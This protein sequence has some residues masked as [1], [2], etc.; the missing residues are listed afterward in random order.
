M[1]PEMFNGDVHR[2][3]DQY[4]LGVVVYE[5]LS[6]ARPFP[7]PGYLQ[8]GHQHVN[9]PPPPLRAKV[10]DLPP[11]VEQV[12]LRALAKDPKQRYPSVRAFAEALVQA[13]REPPLGT[14]VHTLEGHAG[15]VLS[16]AW[17][18]DGTRLASAG[19]DKTVRVWEEASGQALRILR[20]L[21]GSV[22]SVAWSPDGTR[23]AS[24]SDNGEVVLWDAANGKK[25]RTLMEILA[26]LEQEWEFCCWA[27]GVKYPTSETEGFDQFCSSC[28]ADMFSEG[29]LPN[30]SVKAVAWSSNRRYLASAGGLGKIYL[31][32]SAS[33]QSILTCKG[34]TRCVNSV[35][36]SPD[37]R[38]L[39][40]A[41]G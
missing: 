34:H 16:V 40:S 21:G 27:C 9:N 26:F 38:R 41:S 32:D 6:G 19:D 30:Y 20:G 5:W 24:A 25:L 39:A 15:S 28:G 31:W 11:A 22:H 7:G 36:W 37:A 8:Y 14:L 29:K 1:A 2:T 23:L 18:P 17:S 13:V 4:A 3:S 10:P 33:G 12:V 35:A